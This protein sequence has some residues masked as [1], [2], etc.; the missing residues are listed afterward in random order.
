MDQFDYRAKFLQIYDQIK[1]SKRPLFDKMRATVENS[2]WHREA[3]VFVH[4]EMVVDQY[5]RLT[6]NDVY[7][8]TSTD[9]LGALACLFHDTGKPMAETPKYSD[10]RGHY[11]SYHGH[12]VL[13]ARLWED[14]AATAENLCSPEDTAKVSWFIEHHMPWN[15]LKDDKLDNIARTALVYGYDAYSRALLAD[16]YGR[17]AD[18]Q[19]TKNAAAE[20]WTEELRQ[21]AQAL[22]PHYAVTG[23]PVLIMPI[24]TSGAGKSTYLQ[25]HVPAD[26]A[27]FSLDR[28][29][30]EWYD[31]DDYSKAFEL[32]VSD[33]A[34]KSK[35]TA[36][37]MRVL[38]QCAKEGRSLYID[39]TNLSSK[40]RRSYLVAAQTHGFTT[41]AVL[42]PVALQTVI[43][44]QQT[45]S[46]KT[47]P[48]Q[49]VVRQYFSLQTPTLGEFDNI[50]VHRTW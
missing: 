14:Y 25:Q 18:D 22:A 44:R 7:P 43:D 34:F 20:K 31:K 13:S 9:Y 33:S 16:Q 2:P 24:A 50:V 1:Q 5:I 45:R 23:K 19:P 29:R 8:W 35:S 30:H 10:E 46:D 12:E 41:E 40:G 3:N 11:R 21:R 27:V 26:T 6:D 17:I 38:K 48:T 49:A 15:I 28:L 4:T 47:V 37:F 36:E 32:S 42:F 39:N